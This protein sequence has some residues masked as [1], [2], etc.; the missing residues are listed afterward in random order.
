MEELRKRQKEY[1]VHV[2]E[3]VKGQPRDG[4]VDLLSISKDPKAYNEIIAMRKLVMGLAEE[5]VA[6]ANQAF[7]LLDNHLR[8]TEGDIMAAADALRKAGQEVPMVPGVDDY[9]GYEDPRARKGRL[10][11]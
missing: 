2:Q 9:D 3:S 4:S 5:K 7:D 1:I 6:A 8:K 10:P 11:T